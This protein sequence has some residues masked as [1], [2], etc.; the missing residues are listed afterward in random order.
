MNRNRSWSW[1]WALACAG[2]AVVLATLVSLAGAAETAK[3]EA[4]MELRLGSIGIAPGW[5]PFT[6][7]QWTSNP[8]W[9][10]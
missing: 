1:P 8:T 10:R 7:P 4:P 3:A 9:E 6:P 2:H 5:I